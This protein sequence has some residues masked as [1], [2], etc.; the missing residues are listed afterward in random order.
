MQDDLS[1][2]IVIEEGQKGV[3]KVI[4]SNPPTNSM[5]SNVLAELANTIETLSERTDLQVIV[6]QSG[7]ERTFCSGADFNELLQ[8]KDEI[9]GKKFFTGFAKIIN[10][11]RKS[12]QIVIGRV[13]GK[14]VGGGVGLAAAT[15]YCFATKFAS[16]K[17]SELNIGIIPAVIEPAVERKIGLVAFTEMSLN[18]HEFF[19]ATWAKEK[20]LFM[21]VF[22]DS[23]TMD[24]AVENLANRLTTYSKPALYELKKILWKNTE[25]WDIL[26]SER[27]EIS[28]R[29]VLGLDLGNSV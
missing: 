23:P 19:T 15:D 21:E 6:L 28:G 26:L 5:P 4:F 22:E 24:E 3:A 1:K 7:G 13:Q 11:I 18:P 27:A 8:I 2:A 12:P 25:H 29:L 20:G 10:A 9:S 17:L 16:I 14:A